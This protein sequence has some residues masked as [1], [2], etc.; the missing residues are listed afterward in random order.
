MAQFFSP[1]AR[2]TKSKPTHCE[3]TA[4]QL[5]HQGKAVAHHQGKVIFIEGLLPGEQAKVAVTKD[6]G[7]FA[8]AEVIKRLSDSDQRVKPDCKLFDRCGGCQLQYA[9]PEGQREFKQQALHNLIGHHLDGSAHQMAE[10]ITGEPW[11]YRRR[12]R[13]GVR[14]HKG[15]L[16]LGFRQKLSNTLV[17]VPHCPVLAEPLSQ[18]I[19]PLQQQLETMP[20][21]KHLGHVDLLLASEGTVVV[22]RLLRQLTSAERTELEQ[23]QTQQQCLLLV[24]GGSSI[25]DLDGDE[26]APLHYQIGPQLPEV[27]FLPGD[28]FQVNDQV[29]QKMIAQALD[30]LDPQQDETGLDLFCGS[31]NFSFA[32]ANRSAAVV[33][34]E[35]VEAMAQRA[36]TRADE[37]GISNISF[38]S[39]DLNGDVPTDKWAQQ[40]VD[41]VLLDPARA[42][43]GGALKWL[44]QLAPKRILYVSCAPLTLAQDAKMLSQ[45]G[46][47]LSRLGLVDMFPHTGH[48]ESMALFVRK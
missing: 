43:A 30:W 21:A 8:S 48:L 6:K 27:A 35:G 2:K 1:K 32:L 45:H 44:P 4:E 7:R 34:V 24:D 10:P 22:L 39:A 13:L 26:A 46:Y 41:W 20:L 18:L 33:G 29:N 36:Q 47:S 17:N 40:P 25:T 5:D 28:F 11:G 9:S 31:G 12:A 38:F 23:W 3:V 37:L 19:T 42:G 14:F 15:K 16:T